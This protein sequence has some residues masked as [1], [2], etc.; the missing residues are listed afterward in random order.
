M[1]SS[2]R[3]KRAKTDP[4]TTSNPEK[5]MNTQTPTVTLTETTIELTADRCVVFSGRARLVVSVGNLLV[6]GKSITPESGRVDL[7]ADE[8]YGG[9]IIIQTAAGTATIPLATPATATFTLLPSFQRTSNSKSK[10]STTTTTTTS[11]T[12][13]Y[14]II[15]LQDIHPPCPDLWNEAAINISSPSTLSSSS[16]C[17]SKSPLSPPLVAAIA[18]PK[19]M[20]KSTFSRLLVNSLLNKHSAVFYLDSD[21]GQPDLTTPG[22]VS[23]HL[24]EQ[25][26]FGPPHIRLSSSSS[27]SSSPKLLKSFFIGDTSPA[28]DPER[29]LDC[30]RQLVHCYQSHRDSSQ[31]KTHAHRHKG[32]LF[33]LVVNT[34]GWIRGAG[35]DVLV[36]ILRVLPLTHF[37]QM[38]SLN[39][40]KNLPSGM[41]W[42]DHDG[43]IDGSRAGGGV[44]MWTLPPPIICTGGHDGEEGGGGGGGGGMGTSPVD[45][46]TLM[47]SAWAQRC[48]DAMIDSSNGDGDGDDD[49]AKQL[50]RIV[51]YEVS[52]K[53]IE[54][55]VVPTCVSIPGQELLRA[56]NASIVGLCMRSRRR[57]KKGEGEGEDDDEGELECLGI[58][59]VKAADGKSK[60]LLF[61]T[62][63]DGERLEEVSVIQLGRLELPAV[64]CRSGGPYFA[65][66]GL[67]VMG[68]GAG[69]GKARNNLLRASFL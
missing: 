26:L 30:I 4:S 41:F 35:L 1:S 21:C 27:S 56:L 69:T 2:G 57:N 66:F 38:A 16:T 50:R 65:L 45:Q 13:T 20:G 7:I 63:I 19:R 8:N 59:L 58:G 42:T 68:T 9:P 28:N 3:K 17:T 32:T 61:L 31:T 12:Y 49:V 55:E 15:N 53:D 44:H 18:G 33:P 54:I 48:I 39:V 24:V 62:D 23:L 14:Q 10:H 67:N 29:Y 46:R 6:F 25:P 43:D 5:D 36:E 60:R 34:H 47:W 40:G 37:I 11:T 52:L 22:Q 51:P 64:L